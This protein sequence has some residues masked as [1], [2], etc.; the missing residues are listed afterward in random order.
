MDRSFF[1]FYVNKMSCKLSHFFLSFVRSMPKPH[2]C[3]CTQYT[4]HASKRT[5]YQN[6]N[7][8]NDCFGQNAD[9]PQMFDC[10]HGTDFIEDE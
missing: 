9:F 6:W 2:M 4:T 7:A 8:E 1:G 3:A 5:S 10:I